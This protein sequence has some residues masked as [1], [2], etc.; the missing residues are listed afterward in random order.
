MESVSEY[1]L[2]GNTHNLGRGV[3]R[4]LVGRVAKTVA[5][6]PGCLQVVLAE[7]G[8]RV[9]S[10]AAAAW[11]LSDEEEGDQQTAVVDAVGEKVQNPSEFRAEFSKT[12][13][14]S[15]AK[16]WRS[17]PSARL[18]IARVTLDL[19]VDFLRRV[20]YLASRRWQV[21]E[22]ARLVK[23]GGAAKLRLS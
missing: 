11:A 1:S 8:P 9:A 2:I 19:G 6:P 12:Q 17:D 20:E 21:R 23:E 5:R 3:L 14:Q 22:W 4:W 18:L 15:A 7:R 16:F 13:K 10:S